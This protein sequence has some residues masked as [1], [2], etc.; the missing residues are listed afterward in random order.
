MFVSDHP[1]IRSTRRMTNVAATSKVA[2][3]LTNLLR[4]A[5]N[6]LSSTNELTPH[7]NLRVTS[8][9]MQAEDLA[10][11]FADYRGVT[12]VGAEDGPNRFGFRDARTERFR[13]V[14]LQYA[15]DLAR[16]AHMS[17]QPTPGVA[18]E[19]AVSWKLS[20]TNRY[21]SVHYLDLSANVRSNAPYLV[22]L[23]GGV[24]TNGR[25]IPPRYLMSG[26]YNPVE[27]PPSIWVGDIR[28]VH[29]RIFASTNGTMLWSH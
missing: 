25:L 13:A 7:E 15:T 5:K 3:A 24:T 4:Q 23:E 19:G 28:E 27:E 2:E 21:S 11:V 1:A 22:T 14:L 17:V 10:R 9:V 16:R 12:R 18:I 29:F 20:V 6:V 8:V 26:R